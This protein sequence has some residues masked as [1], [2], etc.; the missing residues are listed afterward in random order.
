[1]CSAVRSRELNGLPCGRPP[2]P[3]LFRETVALRCQLGEPRC[4]IPSRFS[5]VCI[6][7][8]W[9]SCII[10]LHV[11]VVKSF[12]S[13]CFD[14]SEFCFLF[15]AT[16]SLCHLSPVFLRFRLLHCSVVSSANETAQRPIFPTCFKGSQFRR[17]P[18]YTRLAICFTRRW[19][20]LPIL[21]SSRYSRLL[22]SAVS[23]LGNLPSCA[24]LL[25]AR[26]LPV[27]E[28]IMI[29]SAKISVYISPWPWKNENVW[30]NRSLFQAVKKEMRI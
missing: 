26:Y 10:C 29:T 22:S 16:S 18:V 14:R 13:M 6:V 23:M 3:M 4:G 20:I 8:P 27:S 17:Y 30:S 25:A 2:Y 12:I 19:S 5:L 28:T 1:M 7:L 15:V 9:I 21:L 11:N 24:Q